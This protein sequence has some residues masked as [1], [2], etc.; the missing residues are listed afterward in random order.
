MSVMVINP[1][2]Y[3]RIAKML[4]SPGRVYEDLAK[5]VYTYRDQLISR[6]QFGGN[7]NEDTKMRFIVSW[8]ERVYVAN[9]MAYIFNYR[10]EEQTISFLEESH[11]KFNPMSMKAMYEELEGIEYNL[12]TGAA[13]T[14]LS[15][16]DMTRLQN[17]KASIAKEI[18][19]GAPKMNIPECRNTA[20][21]VFHNRD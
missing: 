10:D 9:Q 20:D 4:V 1:E 3:G 12:Y 5:A 2:T 11:L 18:I 14:F 17:L 21:L 8:M 19:R 6:G 7:D 16:E 13:R 15:E